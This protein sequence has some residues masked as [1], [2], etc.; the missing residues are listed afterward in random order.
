MK[1]KIPLKEWLPLIGLTFSAF[2]FNTS[3]F[4]PIGL[5]SDI[6]ADLKITEANAGMLISVYAWFVAFLSLPL[7]LVVAKMERKRLMLGVIVVFIV[8][9]ILSA[10]AT[11]FYTLMAS[12][13][14]V[15]CAHSIFWA[16][17]SPMAV[18]VVSEK[19]QSLALGM[20]VTGTSIAMIVGLPLGR[21]IGL[22]LGWRMAF[23]SIAVVA[24]IIAIYM[25]VVFPKMESRKPFQINSLPKLLQN[26]VLTGIFLTTVVLVVGHYTAYSYIEPFLAQAAHMPESYV[27]FT[28]IVFGAAGIGGSFLF[29]RYFNRNPK[30]FIKTCMWGVAVLLLC[31][32]VS[33]MSMVSVIVVCALWGMVIT[34]FNV[35]FQAEIIRYSPDSDSSTIAMAIF[36]GIYNLGIG[37]GA[38]SGATVV[39]DLSIGYIGYAGGILVVA[40]AIYAMKALLPYMNKTSD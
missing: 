6:A 25:F 8:S 3:E 19:H 29:S 36:S 5:L 4:M 39:T 40:A 27:T 26:R 32:G 14:G 2:V 37:F 28:L 13:I 18:R 30:L 34:A 21:I 33:A 31:L 22:Q 16:I 10:F 9:H 15:A 1:E 7:M 23:M 20:I 38:L 12:R 11:N 35:S 17:A 24:T